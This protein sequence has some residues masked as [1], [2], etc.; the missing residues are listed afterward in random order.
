MENVPNFLYLYNSSKTNCSNMSKKWYKLSIH[1]RMAYLNDID[2]KR[3]H[4]GYYLKFHRNIQSITLPQ[5]AK[6][7]ELYHHTLESIEL[8]NNYPTYEVSIK[9][10]QY[11][12]LTTKYFYDAYLEETDQLN[13]KLNNYMKNKN[14]N[15]MQLSKYLGIDRRSISSWIYKNK[16]PSRQ[17]YRKLKEKNII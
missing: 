5:L 10:S 8:L 7:L 4:P 9:L 14:M 12:G 13:I 16:K 6:E 17:S 1:P 2:R 3:H 15:M 11:F